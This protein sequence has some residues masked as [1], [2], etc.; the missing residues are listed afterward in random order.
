MYQKTS[1]AFAEGATKQGT[2][3]GGVPS[4]PDLVDLAEKG[5]LYGL[6]NALGR[7]HEALQAAKVR[8]ANTS[9]TYL[10]DHPRG[11]L[12]A[13]EIAGETIPQPETPDELIRALTGYAQQ[14]YNRNE[15]WK[16]HGDSTG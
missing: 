16:N 4:L 10:T 3:S 1:K 6:Y 12:R 14:N 13:A 7:R 8:K 5:D 2:G 11:T 9:L 15:W